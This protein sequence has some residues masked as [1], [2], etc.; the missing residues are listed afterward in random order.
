MLIFTKEHNSISSEQL[1]IITQHRNIYSIW[2]Y[3]VD[4]WQY[5]CIYEITQKIL[6][7]LVKIIDESE[8]T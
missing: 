5:Y 8:W 1:T 7:N 4:R 2:H 3:I 6:T